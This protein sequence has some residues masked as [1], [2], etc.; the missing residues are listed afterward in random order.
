[1]KTKNPGMIGKVKNAIVGAIQGSGDVVQ[2]TVTT[3]T[4]TL[5]TAIRDSGRPIKGVELALNE[6]ETAASAN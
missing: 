6:P 3:I 5:S 4:H 1:M 2:A